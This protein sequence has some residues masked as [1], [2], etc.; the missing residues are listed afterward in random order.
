MPTLKLQNRDCARL[1]S[2]KPKIWYNLLVVNGKGPK[3]L[4]LVWERDNPIKQII[5][6]DWNS[7]SKLDQVSGVDQRD[8]I[9]EYTIYEV[10]L[11]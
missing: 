9:I 8:R 2:P 4:L 5:Y 3:F 10:L 7:H 1:Q 11:D 6:Q